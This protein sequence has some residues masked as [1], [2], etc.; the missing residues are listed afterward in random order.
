MQVRCYNEAPPRAVIVSIPR[1]CLTAII[2]ITLDLILVCVPAW[3]GNNGTP[4]IALHLTA[5]TSKSGTTCGTWAP[6][7]VP[8]TEFETAGRLLTPYD[9]YVV[10]VDP[11]T[12]SGNGPR[13]IAGIQWGMYYNGIAHEGLDI[14]SWTLCGD[15]EWRL[16]D[17]PAPNVGTIVT[18]VNL[19]NCQTSQPGEPGV[20][21][22][23]GSFYVYAYSD[24]ALSVI[25]AQYGMVA[26]LLKVA[27]CDNAE[28]AVDPSTARGAIVFSSSGTTAG[29]NPCTGSGTLPPLP[30]PPPPVE[31]PPP[32]PSGEQAAAVLL[33]AA[34]KALRGGS[35]DTGPTDPDSIVTWIAVP[36]PSEFA[37]YVLAAPKVP[38]DEVGVRSI[39]Y[40]ISYRSGEGT[41]VEVIDWH[42][43]SD[44]YVPT[45]DWPRSNTGMTSIW[46]DCQLGKINVA[47]YFILSVHDPSLFAIVP[48][49][50]QQKVTYTN[51]KA[52]SFR[53]IPLS[54]AGWISFGGASLGPDA[55]GCNPLAAPC[56][57]G[58]ASP[59]RTTWGKIKT[60]Y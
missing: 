7:N 51:C 10:A 30:G 42:S 40:G 39:G 56:A 32:P 26:D 48:H 46:G 59:N 50:S 58:P 24:D 36:E 55:D 15:L 44:T 19:D 11:D 45:D 53:E 33:H 17:W 37:V 6:K 60:K 16:D 57:R 41:G 49:P 38:D 25:P 14:F 35:C 47:G 3:A 12:G 29:F 18:W 34:P 52:L 20:Q 22:I 13:G 43:C 9:V 31:P 1:N 5:H 21:A 8:C 23:P 2:L 27:S 28:H 4:M 54:S